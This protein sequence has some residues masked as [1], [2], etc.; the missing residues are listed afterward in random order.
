M[1][2]IA[3]HYLWWI[4]ALLLIGGEVIL[5]G[6][7]MLW[8]GIAA[9]AMGVVLLLLPDLGALAQNHIIESEVEHTL[10][11]DNIVIVRNYGRALIVYVSQLMEREVAEAELVVGAEARLE[12]G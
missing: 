3:M 2:G 8:I 4:V 5:P 12:C 9:A 7:F 6:Y 1:D 11:A 10:R